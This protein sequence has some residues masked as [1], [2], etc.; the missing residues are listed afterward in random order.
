[1]SCPDGML[2]GGLALITKSGAVADVKFAVTA[3]GPLKVNACGVVVPLNAPL[4]PE[5]W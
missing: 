5:N 1:M 3:N 4:K 2:W